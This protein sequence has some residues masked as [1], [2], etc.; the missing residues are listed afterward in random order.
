MNVFSFNWLL[1]GITCLFSTVTSGSDGIVTIRGDL[2]LNFYNNSAFIGGT[3]GVDYSWSVNA[4]WRPHVGLMYSIRRFSQTYE[5]NP[6]PLPS[7]SLSVTGL[8]RHYS[9]DYKVTQIYIPVLLEYQTSSTEMLDSYIG[10]GAIFLLNTSERGWGEE[11]RFDLNGVLDPGPYNY[12]L[13]SSKAPPLSLDYLGGII[14]SGIR[15][16]IRENIIVNP[17]LTVL[18]PINRSRIDVGYSSTVSLGIGIGYKFG[19]V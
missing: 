11:Y 10:A 12:T 9:L 2:D 1:T 14:Q 8:S 17:T 3:T 16:K 6:E 13:V 5:L 15:I 4:K 7:N 18:I 19:R